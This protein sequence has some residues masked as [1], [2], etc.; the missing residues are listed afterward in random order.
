MRRFVWF[1]VFICVACLPA[2][3]LWTDA[4]RAQTGTLTPADISTPTPTVQPILVPTPLPTPDVP[5]GVRAYRVR[6]GDTLLAVALETG[7]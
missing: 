2:V 5:P 4:A 3:G 7:V 1:V 6:A